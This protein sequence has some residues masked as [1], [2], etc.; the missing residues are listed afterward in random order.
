MCKTWNVLLWFVEFLEN[1]VSRN[2][3][4]QIETISYLLR[5][6]YFLHIQQV[7][8]KCVIFDLHIFY[9]MQS[10]ITRD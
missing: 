7:K 2:F 10:K 8:I 3:D 6:V 1:S 4:Y 9:F 5:S